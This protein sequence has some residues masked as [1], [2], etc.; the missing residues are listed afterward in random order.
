MIKGKWIANLIARV[1]DGSISFSE[2][3]SF[4][5]WRFG[6]KRRWLE[7]EGVSFENVDRITWGLISGILVNREYNPSGYEIGPDDVVVDMGTLFASL[8]SLLLSLSFKIDDT[9]SSR[10]LLC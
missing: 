10:G 7:I 2:A 9:T 5:G 4:I 6:R 1:G 8:L 3:V